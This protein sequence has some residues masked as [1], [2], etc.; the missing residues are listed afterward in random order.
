MAR[1]RAEQEDGDRGRMGLEGTPD[2]P[3]RSESGSE[4]DEVRIEGS[5]PRHQGVTSKEFDPEEPEELRPRAGGQ[6]GSLQGLS[7]DADADSESVDELLEEGNPFEAGIV[8]A[9]EDARDA[10][11]GE[12]ETRE[13]PED[14]VNEEY[15][16]SDR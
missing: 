8:Q 4:E 12:I 9:V 3:T 6:A 2:R 13:V 16:D 10:D 5:R 7:D 14:D 1:K 15:Q 11:Q